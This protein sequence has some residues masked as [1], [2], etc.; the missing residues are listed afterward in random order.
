MANACEEV[1]KTEPLCTAGRKQI[2]T[3]TTGNSMS[4]IKNFKN[5]TKI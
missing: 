2:G 5:R 1:D 4:Y 3:V